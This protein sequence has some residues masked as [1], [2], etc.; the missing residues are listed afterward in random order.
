MSSRLF[1]FVINNTEVEEQ[2]RRAPVQ[3]SADDSSIEVGS[4]VGG[5]AQQ[6]R[7]IGTDNTYR[8]E[9]ALINKYRDC[10]SSPFIDNAVDAITTEAIVNDD[11]SKNSVEVKFTEDTALPDTLQKQIQQEFDYVLKMFDFK[12]SG[13]DIF[14]RWYVDG[15]IYFF[16]VIDEK[17]PGAGIKEL[18]YIDPRKI[19]KVRMYG[20]DRDKPVDQFSAMNVSFVEFWL[21]CDTGLDSGAQS[22]MTSIPQGQNI[23]SIAKDSIAYSTSGMF[24]PSGKMIISHLHKILRT[25]NQFRMLED[26]VVIYRMVRASEK[27]KFLIDVGNLPKPKAEAAM[28]D[29]MVKFKNKLE[30]NATTGELVNDRRY[31]AMTE[32]YWFAVRGGQQGTDV[33]QFPGGASLGEVDDL[34]LFKETLFRGLNVPISRIDPG[35]ATVDF[36]SNGSQI[37]RDELSFNRFINRLRARFT[38]IL[39][40]VLS[41]QLVLKGIVTK[42]EWDDF[43][44]QVIFEWARDSYYAELKD[45]EIIQTKMQAAGLAL[46][47]LKILVSREYI[48]REIF[49]FDDQQIKDMTKQLDDDFSVLSEQEAQAAMMMQPPP[50]PNGMDNPTDMNVP[51]GESFL[52]DSIEDVQLKGAMI[53]LFE[54]MTHKKG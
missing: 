22:Y 46:P 17:N 11:G 53:K 54:R 37:S 35:A 20:N 5:M 12:L 8:S 39:Q 13:H 47:L 7:I 26:A 36:S 18:R 32:D 1:G 27:R 51:V 40:D 19:K 16:K 21:F 33:E 34:R 52:F 25:F 44:D 14:R 15:R 49:K 6:Q 50:E 30:Y 10:A 45:I 41:S 29:L 42:E 2:I 9:N 4:P 28:R 23:I 24:D 48:W 43:K 3:P 38:L 31:V